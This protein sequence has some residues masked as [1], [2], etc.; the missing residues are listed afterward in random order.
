MNLAELTV[1]AF[2]PLVGSTFVLRAADGEIQAELVG[3]T[4]SP[5]PV[6][7][8]IRAPFTLTWIGPPEPRLQQGIH[9]VEHPRLAEPIEL[10]LVPVGPPT[11]APEY[12][13]QLA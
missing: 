1:D 12:E 9:A 6:P 13:A 8:G 11:D 7:E 3:A 10:F 2:A 5:H 4:P